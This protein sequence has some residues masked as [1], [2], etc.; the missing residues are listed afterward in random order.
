[1]IPKPDSIRNKGRS[2]SWSGSGGKNTAKV[3]NT[4]RNIIPEIKTMKRRGI[5]IL[6]T[7]DRDAILDVL[8][9]RSGDEIPECGDGE[10]G[11]RDV[12][13][14]CG[15]N[16]RTT[17]TNSGSGGKNTAKV[18]NTDRNIIPENKTM[19]RNVALTRDAGDE[20]KTAWQAGQ[21][22]ENAP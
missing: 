1:M 12:R 14:Q 8:E 10:W 18:H 16:G 7:L 20:T 13:I 4:D 11:R 22:E 6:D 19:K 3:H 17:I 9:G 5:E 21:Y 2:F 15:R